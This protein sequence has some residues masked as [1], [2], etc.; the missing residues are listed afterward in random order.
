M[1][2]GGGAAGA[3]WLL[4]TRHTRHA[5]FLPLAAVCPAPLW[6]ICLLQDPYEQLRMSINAVFGSWNTPRAVKYRCGSDG[7]SRAG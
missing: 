7:R 3:R 6:Y 5:S 2:H 4:P 1:L